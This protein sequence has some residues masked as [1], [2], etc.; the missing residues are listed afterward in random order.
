MFQALV[1]ASKISTYEAD[2]EDFQYIVKATVG[3]I[4]LGTPHRG[5]EFAQWGL[6]TAVTGQIFG[7]K[8]YPEQ[9]KALQI[10]STTSILPALNEDFANIKASESLL[11]LKVVCFYETKEVSFGVGFSSS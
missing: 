3:I 8:A 7:L 5:S 1:I 9:L 4:F 10:D 11:G 2:Y 6:W